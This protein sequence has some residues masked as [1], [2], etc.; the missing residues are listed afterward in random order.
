MQDDFIAVDLA[1]EGDRAGA[2]G[3]IRFEGKR[4]P[5]DRAVV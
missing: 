1:G 3:T 4:T 2:V 5:V